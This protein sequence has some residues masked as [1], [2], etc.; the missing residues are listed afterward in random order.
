MPVT[1]RAHA[2]TAE[3]GEITRTVVFGNRPLWVHENG[4]DVF[5]ARPNA[6]TPS[7][8]AN[9]TEATVGS[10]WVGLAVIADKLINFSQVVGE[11]S[12]SER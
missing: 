5:G 10:G 12:P 3:V 11:R 1:H 6:A 9:T 7:T 4:G 8:A 2:P